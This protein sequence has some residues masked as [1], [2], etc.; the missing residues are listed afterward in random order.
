MHRD[1]KPSNILLAAIS[2]PA[3]LADFGIAWRDG[4]RDSEKPDEKITDVGT[5]CYRAPELLFG[6]SGYGE[7]VDLWA[8]GCVVAEVEREGRE[9]WDAG[10]GGS[11]LALLQSVFEGLGTPNEERWPVSAM[12]LWGIVAERGLGCVLDVQERW[13]DR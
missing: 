2:G 9:L 10:E 7:G 5:S 6:W 11:E 3:Y 1:V 8:A 4:D 13:I 12:H